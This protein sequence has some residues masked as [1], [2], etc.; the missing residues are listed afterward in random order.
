MTK[1]F[2]VINNYKLDDITT[3]IK[4]VSSVIFA[5]VYY[6]NSQHVY[7]S[8]T[9]TLDQSDSWTQPCHVRVLLNI[10]VVDSILSTKYECPG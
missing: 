2:N 1:Y 4:A 7:R 8:F 6:H 3:F 5:E 10:H 9:I